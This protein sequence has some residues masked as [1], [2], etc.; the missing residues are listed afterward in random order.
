M[1][2]T[3][4]A[5]SARAAFPASKY[6]CVSCV[7]PGSDSAKTCDVRKT[8][9]NGF[10]LKAADVQGVNMPSLNIRNAADVP[11]HNKSNAVVRAQQSLYEGFIREAGTENVGELHLADGEN[12]RSVKVR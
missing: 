2:T 8:A 12:E 10:Y 4:L 5:T 6:S 7:V 3:P 1:S 9:D 11:T